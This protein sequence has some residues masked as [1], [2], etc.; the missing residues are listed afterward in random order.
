MSNKPMPD[1]AQEKLEPIVAYHADLCRFR[2]LMAAQEK[3]EDEAKHAYEQEPEPTVELEQL[4][5]SLL[6]GSGVVQPVFERV[7]GRLVQ[8]LP[9]YRGE[10]NVWDLALHGHY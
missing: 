1:V 3:A 9:F 10:V 4:R 2:E 8:P 5:Q 6:Y 7:I